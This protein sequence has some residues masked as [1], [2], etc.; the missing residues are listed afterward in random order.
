[1][2]EECFA[3]VASDRSLQQ[4]I[5]GL[6]KGAHLLKYGRRGKPKFCP[7]RLSTDEKFLIWYSGEDER[8][9]KLS[10]VTKI[11][12]GQKTTNFQ[13]QLQP[14]KESQSFSIV[15]ANGQHSLDL[16]CKDKAQAETWYLGL[17]ALILEINQSRSAVPPKIP[18]ATQSCVSSPS[19]FSRR[20]LKWGLLQEEKETLKFSQVK[21][22]SGA[23]PLSY[24][25]RRS[26]KNFSCSSDTFHSESSL[27]STQNLTEIS[28]PNSPYVEPNKC[29]EFQ[30]PVNSSSE[31]GKNILRDV[32]IWGEGI[33]GGCL[34]GFDKFSKQNGKILDA[35][36]PKQLE[37]IKSLDVSKIS[38]GRT[39]VALVNKQGEVFCW[40]DGT[41]GRLG[42][43]LNMDITYPKIIDSLFTD[44]VKNVVCGEYQSCAITNSGE[45]YTW[46]DSCQCD[47]VEGDNSCLPRKIFGSLNG[48]FV[49][50]VA[51]GEWHMA[52]LSTS[53]QLFTCGNGTF[54]VLGHGDSRNISRPKSVESLEGFFVKSVACGPWHTAAIVDIS[55][56]GYKLYTWGDGDKGRLGHNDQEKKLI[57]TLVEQLLDQ[58][59]T[60][61]ACG[62]TLTAAVNDRGKVLTIGSGSHG[63]LGNPRAKDNSIN[64]VQGELRNEFVTELAIGSYHI[65]VLT[66]SGRVY[67]WGKGSNGQLGLGDSND[68]NCPTS[69]DS[70]RERQVES[71][72]C[73]SNLTAVICLH[74][75][76]SSTD[77]SACKGCG[78]SFS[79]TRKKHNCYNCG[80]L[81]CHN[82]SNK[83]TLDAS[84]APSRDKYFR[85]CDTCY[86]RIKGNIVGDKTV[87][88]EDRSPR[89]YFTSRKRVCDENVEKERD[90]IATPCKVMLNRKSLNEESQ[91]IER[92]GHVSRPIY[93]ENPQII[94]NNDDRKIQ[95]SSTSRVGSQHITLNLRYSNSISKSE[96]FLDLDNVHTKEVQKLRAEVERLEKLCQKRS[97][98]IEKYKK[99]V[100]ETWSL[101]KEEAE[102]SKAAKEVVKIL[103]SNIR[104][105]SEKL[106]GEKELKDQIGSHLSQVAAMDLIDTPTLTKLNT[107]IIATYL[108]KEDEKEDA[109]VCISP[110]MFSNTPKSL[111][112]KDA[113]IVLEDE[114]NEKKVELVEKYDSGVY[115][116]FTELAKGIKTLKR[117]Q[118]SRKRFT[119][120]EAEK[121][122]KENERAVYKK[123]EIGNFVSSNHDD[124]VG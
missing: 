71:V 112:S 57:P 53:G 27:S 42:N 92:W 23:S 108:E 51:C 89:L 26:S 45:L 121:W 21:S 69:V 33:E 61:V 28:S 58:N 40:G 91:G 119:G 37:S 7:F 13:R 47:E 80:L 66:L 102:K 1:M 4:A 117:V 30:I 35:L 86:I 98:K 94:K 34:G 111:S 101:A 83:K 6:K 43:K 84:L 123:Y 107:M 114:L 116:T 56:G 74:K 104:G 72:I 25:V 44:H 19:G 50:Q 10:S 68:R 24:S 100:E 39:H 115:I 103:T 65:A 97:E 75:S 14:D 78:A 3:T 18:R 99:K 31:K 17:R 124:V 36:L 2:S 64:L 48:I 11:I 52:I 109:N 113:H 67:T 5:V 87:K 32:L 20:K 54:G 41:R 77:Q 62:V 15:Y 88:L 12:R 76:I 106:C 60:Q 82:C 16:I 122:W 63:E 90:I 118:F 38:L 120:K 9:L 8:Q 85:V 105:V 96:R 55:P 95:V 46:G 59:F 81:F 29:S 110:I 22:L 70:L 49:S 79:F 93:F 73:G